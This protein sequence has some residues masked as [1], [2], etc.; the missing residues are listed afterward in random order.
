VER[1]YDHENEISSGGDGSV[2]AS[3]E[4]ASLCVYNHHIGPV[5][6]IVAGPSPGNAVFSGAS[7]AFIVNNVDAAGNPP[8]L[9]V[10]RSI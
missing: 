2:G 6:V 10:R 5:P 1:F 3:V 9:A 4:F 8:S 7:G